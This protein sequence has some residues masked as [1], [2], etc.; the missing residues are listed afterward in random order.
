MS[1]LTNWAFRQ[2]S[3]QQHLFSPFAIDTWYNATPHQQSHQVHIDLMYNDL[4][5]N[6][7]VNDNELNVSWVSDLT[8]EYRCLFDIP[9]QQEA[10]LIFE[11][12]DTEAVVVLNSDVI[13]Q[14]KNAFQKHKVAVNL[15]RENE[16]VVRLNSGVEMG[17]RLESKYGSR[18]CWNGD[19]SRVY[20][21]KPQFQYGWDWGPKLITCG[22]SKAVL[23][24]GNY[25]DDFFIRYEL[26]E[27]LNKAYVWFEVAS[28]LITPVGQAKIE[29]SL[30][31]EI[32]GVIY[33]DRVDSAMNIS[34]VLEDVRLWYPV[35]QGEPNLYNVR[36]F[37][38]D[39]L[40]IAKSV[41]FRKV[42]LVTTLDV[43]GSS[44]Y[45]KINNKPI[46]MVGSNWIP[47]HSFVSQ[48]T[49]QDYQ[50]YVDLV[51]GSNQNMIRV[52]GGGQFE[53]DE[54]YQL[55]DVNGILVWQDFMFAC[56]VYPFEPI[57]QSVRK[58]IEYQV[59]RLRN[60]A[61]IV[62]YTGNNEDYQIADALKLNV[63]NI[64]Q[65]P[66][67]SIYEELIPSILAN[68]NTQVA[69]RFGSPYSD[70]K[71]SSYDS[72]YG[73]SHQWDVWHGRKLPY[74][75][76][77]QLTARFVSEF[78]ML[79]LPSY[80]LLG[81]YIT[82][83]KE[84]RPDSNMINFHTKPSNKENLAQYVWSNF[85][86]PQTYDLNDWIY[87]TQLMQSEAVSLAFRYWRRKWEHFQCGGALVW[88]LND[89]WPSVSW[90]VVDF[91]KVPKLSYY[92]MKR[93]LNEVSI[94][95][96]RSIG[97]EEGDGFA[98]QT[99]LQES[100]LTFDVW[101]FGNVSN[102]TLI[103]EFY[104][105]SGDF[106]DGYKQNDIA[107]EENKVNTIFA[108]AT[109]DQLHRETIVYLRL[110]KDNVT[111]ARSSDWPQPLKRLNWSKLT[112]K[113]QITTQYIGSGE[114]QV[115]TNKP[116]KGL[117]LYF[118]NART[119]RFS[120]NGIDLFP[121]DPQI[122]QVSDFQDDGAMGEI[123]YRYLSY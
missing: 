93:E 8:W 94:A 52:W 119:Y 95:G 74:Q 116:V 49:K 20:V 36:L 51:L 96:Y 90:S 104:N 89:C 43:Y 56:G 30:D 31:E 121:G 48:V 2:S 7:F 114:L 71:H 17:K 103:I 9:T 35:K 46:Q 110:S 66:A 32:V 80:S 72:Q 21:R 10:Y 120:D 86:K 37:Y 112:S 57:H 99:V 28:I 40:A 92:G 61:S 15:S 47:S 63:G 16:L 39:K 5:P 33:I 85:N 84:L 58:E 62:I 75:S 82:D 1:V 101:G 6:P 44:F 19:C 123:K 113:L 53:N 60:F 107:L 11:Q 50:D 88:Q 78:G 117:Q 122:I 87:L 4:I 79:A 23:V 3:P 77:P 100:K 97:T 14:S 83:D 26:S 111:V 65:F 69:Y 73:D 118:D 67:K 59:A 115:S 25:V 76:W 108:S 91:D 102:L 54:F 98:G 81:N 45:F 70:G 42:D 34:Y 24:T 109:F 27:D 106:V 105:S 41:G 29:V 55:C 18:E 38:N 68:M 12:L 64:T 22:F 13:L